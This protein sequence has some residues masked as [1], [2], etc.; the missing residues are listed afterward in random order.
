MLYRFPALFY[1][2][3]PS[4]CSPSGDGRLLSDGDKR[5][6]QL[7]YPGDSGAVNAIAARRESLIETIEG[8]QT[9]ESMGGLESMDFGGPKISGIAAQAAAR[10]RESLKGMK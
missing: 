9:D 5:G 8:P 3:H 7:L 10:L 1:R 4:P 2:T 6:L